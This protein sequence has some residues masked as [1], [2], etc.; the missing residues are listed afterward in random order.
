M[1]VAE[2]IKNFRLTKENLTSTAAWLFILKFMVVAF[3]AGFLVRAIWP[4]KKRHHPI[5][6]VGEGEFNGRNQLEPN[7]ETEIGPNGRNQVE[8]QGVAVQLPIP[9]DG[10]A[11]DQSMHTIVT[12]VRAAVI[13][14]IVL[15]KTPNNAALNQDPATDLTGIK[16][17]DPYAA[18]AK[19]AVGS[20]IIVDANGTFLTTRH[21]VGDNNNV[22]VSL[23]KAGQNQF[24]ARII[25]RDPDSP[26]VMGKIRANQT[27]PF[28]K[29]GNSDVLRTGDVV[30]AIGN[31]FS[32]SGT[33][34]AGIVSGKKDI[35]VEGKL[36]QGAIQTDT[37]INDGNAGGPLVNADGEVVGITFAS[38]VQG[39]NFT[40][41]GFAVPIN[42]AREAWG[43]QQ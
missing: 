5:T 13:K 32:L 31:P 14:V 9:G 1:A 6:I 11:L 28:A 41:I 24:T 21:V 19:M 27:F 17:G 3:A 4:T 40:G 12:Q 20:G 34:T 25:A 8:A 15:P 29:M 39:G 18:N 43:T 33:V 38:F 36:I 42:F 37:A 16:M 30:M 2:Q 22:N 7:M 10:G 23:Y 35:S 26:L